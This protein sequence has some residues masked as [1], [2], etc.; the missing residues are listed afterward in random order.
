MEKYV[1]TKGIIL[2]RIDLNEADQIITIVSQDYGKVSVM[3][4]GSKRLKSKFCGRLETF[5][6]GEFNYF[7]GRDL[8]HLNDLESLCLLKKEAELD[9][10]SRSLLFYMAEVT[11]KLIPEEQ[12]CGEVYQLLSEALIHFESSCSETIFYAY[13]SK[14]LTHLGFMGDWSKSSETTEKI[15]LEKPHFFSSEEGSI[16]SNSSAHPKDL[17]LTPAVIKWVHFMQREDFSTLKGIQGSEKEKAE[18]FLILKS[19]LG[20]IFDRTFKSETFMQNFI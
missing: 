17:K 11:L 20:N 7:Q 13:L 5:Y 12:E 15:D 6:E 3:A 16:H 1:K 19:I 4:K 18:V 2:R 9:L 8:A 14:L 10:K